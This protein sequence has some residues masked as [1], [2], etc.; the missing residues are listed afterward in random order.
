MVGTSEESL[1]PLR[2]MAEGFGWDLFESASCAEGMALLRR[3][4][5]PVVIC[6]QDLPDGNW[7]SLLEEITKLAYQPNLI[8]A[9]RLADDRLWAEVLNLGAYDLLVLPY[10]DEEVHRV[11]SLAWYSTCEAAGGTVARKPPALEPTLGG[12]AED[13]PARAA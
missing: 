4:R 6:E 5:I 2:R 10:D 8:V 1:L 13:R 7:R 9:S 12:G 11:V 3:E